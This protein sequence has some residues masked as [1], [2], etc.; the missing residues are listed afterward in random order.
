MR[1]RAIQCKQVPYIAV[2]SSAPYS[3][4]AL[5]QCA[6]IRIN[7]HYLTLIQRRES[8]I[9]AVKYRVL[10]HSACPCKNYAP[11]CSQPPHKLDYLSK[12]FYI[13]CNFRPAQ[14]F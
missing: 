2:L 11:K 1:S 6:L 14:G 13:V 12:S 8:K 9:P 4:I 10:I 3:N 5:L 7:V